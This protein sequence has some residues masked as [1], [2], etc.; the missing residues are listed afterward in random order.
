[1]A[2]SHSGNKAVPLSF[3]ENRTVSARRHAEF[4]A[5]STPTPSTPVPRHT[6]KGGSLPVG[7]IAVVGG[8]VVAGG[9]L[10]LYR[11]RS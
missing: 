3:E 1:M 5:P 6:N 4:R 8:L 2:T 11:K 9:A 7:P 10:V